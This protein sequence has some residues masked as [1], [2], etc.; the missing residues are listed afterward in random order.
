MDNDIFLYIIIIAVV[1]TFFV[2]ALQYEKILS[3][4]NYLIWQHR[5]KGTHNYDDEAIYKNLQNISKKSFTFSNEKIPYG[6]AKW[7]ISGNDEFNKITDINTIEYYGFSPLRSKQELDFHEYGLLLTQNGIYISFQSNEKDDNGKFYVHSKYFPFQ[8][9]WNVKYDENTKYIKFY[10]KGGKLQQIK[11]EGNKKQING[12]IAGLESLIETGYTYDLETNCIAEKISESII[13]YENNSYDDN[14]VANRI[15]ALGAVYANLPAHFHNELLNGIVNNP[16]GHGLAAE[17]ANNIA[18][19]VKNP[20]IKVER[21]GQNNAKNGADRIVGNVNIQTK[22]LSTAKNSVNAAFNSK[23]D[24]G[25]Y[26]YEGMQ[27]E[28]PKDQYLDAIEIM[29]KRIAEGKVQ[30]HTNPEDAK[31]IVRKGSV[32]WNEAKMI[33][34]GGNI[35]SLKYDVMDGVVQSIPMAGISFVIMFAQAKWAGE[36]NKSAAIS[37]VKAG[38]GSLCMGTLVYAGSQQFAKIFTAKIA[39]QASEKIAAEAVAKNAGLAISF[40]IIL[41]PNIFNTLAGRISKQQLLKNTVVAGG[42]L[43][44]SIAASAGAGA[45]LGSVVPGAGTA[46][47]AVVGTAAG[48]AGGVAGTFATKKIMDQFIED[49]RIEMFAI[50]KEEYLDAVMSITL[51]QKEF[52]AIQK[53]IF[54]RSLENK[55]R[56]MFHYGKSGDTRQYA[57]ENIVDKA[58]NN[59][60]EDRETIKDA[61][62]LEGLSVLSN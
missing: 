15:G 40:G 57:R 61:D 58:I 16:Q 22:Y 10:Y 31:Y 13:Q 28:V 48:I 11:I 18:D 14:A 24:G 29:K 44:S 2:V 54:D 45:V 21:I 7:F 55:L 23:A 12:L 30:G 25:M 59:V 52:D 37:A 3:F 50:L 56:D 42:G 62:I 39:Q 6:R 27:L 35:I 26:R 4:F 8:G 38:V 5:I 53:I 20:F 49:D 17:Y 33:A 19:Q 51:S 32:T 36:D 1:C 43:I 47:G 34:E 60:I 41:V 46:I 9:L